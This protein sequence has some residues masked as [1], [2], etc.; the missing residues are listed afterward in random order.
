MNPPYPE[1]RPLPPEHLPAPS[2]WPPTLGL[3]LTLTLWGLVSSVAIFATGCAV[4]VAAL[5]GW[6]NNLRN[7]TR[8]PS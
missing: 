7:E 4:M 2:L 1:R 3:G 6:I 5:L 8:R